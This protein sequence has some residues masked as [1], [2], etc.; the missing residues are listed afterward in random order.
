MKKYLSILALSL[1]LI[2]LTYGN[3]RPNILVVMS[4]DHGYGDTGYTGHPFVQTPNLDAMAQEGVLF[5]RFYASSPVC[6][7]TRASVMTGRHS[8][9]TNVPDH[10]HYMRPDEITL[11]EALKTAG[12]HTAH[13]GKWHIGSVQPGS[14]TNPGG[15]GF[16][17]W[18]SGLNFFD[19]DPYLSRN[20]VYEQIQGQGTVI[21]TDETIRFLE[22]HYADDEP[23]FIVTWFPAPHDPFGEVPEGIDNADTLYD[24]KTSN[25]NAG[26]YRE[27]TL[28]DQQV[29]RLRETLRRLD[30]EQ[31]TLIIYTGDNGGLVEEFSGGRDKKRSLYEGGLRIPAI[32]EWPGQYEPQTIDT[33]VNLSDLYP[34]LLA[35]TGIQME[36]QPP[37]DGVDLSP[38][39]AGE[40]NERP[41]M[42]FWLFHTLGQHTWNDRFIR[43]MLEAQQAGEPNPYPNRYLKNVGEFPEFGEDGKRG[44]AAWNDWP[45]KLHRIQEAAEEPSFE[46][47]HL[48]N[49]PMEAN[50]LIDQE[51]E[52]FASMR[53]NLESWQQS[54]LDSWSGKDYVQVTP[55]T[56]PNAKLDS[57]NQFLVTADQFPRDSST[58]TYISDNGYISFGTTNTFS[59]QGDWL[60]DSG[61]GAGENQINAY[62]DEEVLTVRLEA[63]TSLRGFGMRYTND[64]VTISGFEGDPG[65]NGEDLDTAIFNA[66]TNELQFS[67]NSWSAIRQITF[68]NPEASTGQTL[69]FSFS[70]G[71]STF[72]EFDYLTNY[73][74]IPAPY[75]GLNLPRTF[76]RT[77]DGNHQPGIYVYDYSD[78]FLQ[79]LKNEGFTDLRIGI[80]IETANDP[81]SLDRVAELFEAVDNRG[82]ICMWYTL[83]DGETG[84]GA[85]QVRDMEAFA[86]AW[87]LI[88]EKFKNEPR[89]LYELLNEPSGYPKDS[90]GAADYLADMYAVIEQAGL[91]EKRVIIDGMGYAGHIQLVADAGWDGALGLHFYG[92]YV[93][94][95]QRNREGWEEGLIGKLSNLENDVYLTEFGTALSPSSEEKRALAVDYLKGLQ[96]GILHSENVR[97]IYHWHGWDNG[98][99][100]SFWGRDKALVD[101]LLRPIVSS[102][103]NLHADEFPRDSSTGNYTSDDGYIS[104]KTTN[105]FSGGSDWLADSGPSANGKV[106]TYNEGEELT[107]E[108]GEGVSL[109]G[110]G[111]R[112]TSDTI[113]IAG[114]NGDPGISGNSV[115]NVSFNAATNRV[116]FDC[117]AWSE[118]GEITLTNLKAT[119]GQTLTVSF[120]GNQSTFT[121]FNYTVDHKPIP[122]ASVAYSFDDDTVFKKLLPSEFTR[123]GAD[124]HTTGAGYLRFSTTNAFAGGT[125]WLADSG[126]ANSE[127]A[128]YIEGRQLA[129][130]I[131]EGALL[132][133]F[134]MRYTNSTV[135]ISGFNGNPEI[136]GENPGSASFN[137]DSGTLQFDV[138]AWSDERQI[139]F[140]NPGATAGQTLVFDFADGQ[141][142]FTEFRYN[143]PGRM[144]LTYP[145][146]DTLRDIQ[147]N[148]HDGNIDPSA[149]GPIPSASSL[150]GESFKFTADNLPEGI[151][152]APAVAIPSGTAART[153]SIWFN[154]EGDSGEYTLFGYGSA[155]PGQYLGLS[156]VNGSLMIR[157]HGGNISY[158][159]GFDFT[160][161]DAGWHHVTLRVNEAATTF[162][163]VDIFLDGK[164]LEVTGEASAGLG[165]SLNTAET[166]LVLGGSS[167]GYWNINRPFEG[168]LD[169]FSVWDRALTNAQIKKVAEVPGRDRPQPVPKNSFQSIQT[170]K[171]SVKSDEIEIPFFGL[172]GRKYILERSNTLAPNSW[173]TVSATPIMENDGAMTFK[174]FM[175]YSERKKF[176]RLQIRYR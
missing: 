124:S 166:A 174:D 24:D 76:G 108:L 19:T 142:T 80:N 167:I 15:A 20:G 32:F 3:Q 33:P 101:H 159:T 130:E 113:T 156:I 41:A 137:A 99:S 132:G 34:T 11:A 168:R 165:Q 154:L 74:P 127:T 66:E 35:L 131:Q 1:S 140:K 56:A 129:V 2:P 126:P 175:D 150:F 123:N 133:G 25:Y 111:I 82:I 72:T 114:L 176:Y 16:D 31:N 170:P 87:R 18:L 50:N 83:E 98:D 17:E 63:G 139:T 75:A 125:G 58:N 162:A 59:G 69:T 79:N 122:Y 67:V 107:I 155:N 9:R 27:I 64:T 138:N 134:G 163:D 85:A 145:E 121:G 102:D 93:S 81:A 116:Q 62:N 115:S 97:G 70:G 92:N 151:V 52:R 91:P 144:Y 21:T 149:Y 135:T 45:W 88:H 110:L 54:V 104:F 14:P 40:Q 30:I 47:Y 57:P 49:D 147:G 5:D 161:R 89:I 94:E 12:Y 117:Y 173:E 39:I 73:K 172:E 23:M 55:E 171:I 109:G 48:I 43:E 112:W 153:I 100:Y 78:T 46:L 86:G 96:A 71:Q 37:L 136:D 146:L 61:S 95:D 143:L 53:A 36:N 164:K 10:G 160:G 90:A 118:S 148:G 51:P 119:T 84:H 22:E 28:L 65:V 7:P 44:H 141:A 4:D 128:A 6:S 26:Y 60:G 77:N 38:I 158:G 105:T 103:Y 42:G 68:A 157:H 120:S 106:D 29:G 8:M 13:F 152:S 169:D